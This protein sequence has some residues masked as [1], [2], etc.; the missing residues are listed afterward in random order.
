[1][2]Y[3]MDG[4]VTVVTGRAGVGKS[5]LML[6][7]AH[8]VTTGGCVTGI[9]CSQGAS[10]LLD[11]E[12]GRVQI[13]ERIRDA[14]IGQDCVTYDC[15]GLD[16]SKAKDIVWLQAIIEKH[17]AKFVGI[18]SLRRLMPS[19]KEN[20]S[21]DMAPALANLAVIAQQTRAA[22]LV[23]HHEGWEKRSRGSTAIMDQVD[24]MFSLRNLAAD[25]DPTGQLRRLTSRGE[26]GKVRFAREPD[27]L[28]MTL[29]DDCRFTAERPITKG[30]EYRVSIIGCLPQKTM[31]AAAKACGASRSTDAWRDAWKA[32]EATGEIEQHDGQWIAATEDS[33]I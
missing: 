3:L 19:K 15:A 1:M 32:L 25:E 16:F 4:C 30:D 23:L 13:V 2:G 7:L 21:D 22:F 17:G 31:T 5:W 8:A 24:A 10:M 33:A 11:G 18:D 14:G 20:D 26:G 12:M 29:G 9:E 27:D 6:E 28:Y